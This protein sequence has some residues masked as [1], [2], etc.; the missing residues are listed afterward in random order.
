MP[1]E[2]K[3][4]VTQIVVVSCRTHCNGCGREMEHVAVSLEEVVN[5]NFWYDD[6]KCQTC[7]SDDI[8]GEN[9]EKQLDPNDD[10]LEMDREVKA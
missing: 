6:G 8:S 7:G 10:T 9:I 3:K 4:K 2:P 1:Y 5:R